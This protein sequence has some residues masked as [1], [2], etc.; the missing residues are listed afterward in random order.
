MNKYSDK[1][2]KIID[3]IATSISLDAVMDEMAFEIFG[4][5]RSLALAGKGC[6]KCGKRADSFPNTNSEE[7]YYRTAL[8]YDC[9]C[10]V[11]ANDEAEL[12]SSL[13]SSC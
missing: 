7:H 9:Q 13:D 6:V 5:S 12:S 11:F 4:R 3:S 1:F 2:D 10:I 8:C